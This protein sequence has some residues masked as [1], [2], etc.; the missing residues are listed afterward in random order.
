[1]REEDWRDGSATTLLVC[2]YAPTEGARDSDR[3]TIIWHRG[4]RAITAPPPPPRD[5][6]DWSICVATG[7]AKLLPNGVAVAARSVVVLREQAAAQGRRLEREA[8]SELVFAL[9]QAAGVAPS[10]RD[11]DG[12]EHAVPRETIEALLAALHLPANSLSQARESMALL[13]RREDSRALPMSAAFRDDEDIFLRLPVRDGRAATRLELALEDGEWRGVDLRAG[14]LETIS[15]R[16]VD[17]RVREGLRARLPRLPLGRHIVSLE[18][19]DCRLTVAPRRCHAPRID[20]RAFG[21]AAQLYSLRRDGDQG[22]GDFTTLSQLGVLAAQH[23]AAMV[24]INPL[25]AL[26]AQDRERA[27]PYYPS[28]RLFLDP[29]YLD[30]VRDGDFFNAPNTGRLVDY[31]AVHGLKQEFLERA[32]KGVEDFAQAQPGARTSLDFE[33]FIAEGGDAL[34]RFACFEAISERRG[35]EDWRRWPGPLRDGEPLALASFARENASRVRYHQSLQQLSE[36]QFAQAARAA[37]KAGLSLGFCRDLAVGAAPDGCESWR[38][39]AHLLKG[40]SIG[41]PPDAFTREGQNWGLPPP[42][43]LRWKAEGCVSFGELLRANMRHAGALRIDHVMGLAR[44]FVVPEGGRPLEGAYLSYPLDDLLAEVALESN[45]AKCAVIGEDLGT[46]PWGF[47]A[48][49]ADSGILSYRVLWFEREGGRFAPPAHYGLM[50][51]ACV[52]THDLPTLKGWWEGSDIA[53]KLALGLLGEEDAR[54]ERETRREDRRLLLEALAREGLLAEGVSPDAP[55]SDALAGGAHAYIA[56]APALLAM[57]QVDDLA[58]ETIAVNLPG[59]DRERPN[60]RRKLDAK[61]AVLFQSGLA[62]AILSGLRR[63]LD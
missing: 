47:S 19:I 12:A 16:G 43:P 56:R 3:V 10:W 11:V 26:F 63:N 51:M 50:A 38:G 28:D 29:I 14:D 31:P 61:T 44:L 18:G 53:E 5:G 40:F 54:K 6:F 27:S 34:F 42:D 41:A 33:S 59:T 60:W 37:E 35:G 46:L 62:Q 8:P 49:L 21:L 9:A 45:R 23:G 32:F 48:R 58:G 24:A 25:H 36:S 57:A 17:D 22:V 4:A 2:L 39:A 55:F 13:A 1:M 30:I 7:S 20:G 15:W 52:S